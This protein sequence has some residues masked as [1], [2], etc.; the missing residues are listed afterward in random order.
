MRTNV[1]LS[2]IFLLI[3]ESI[4]FEVWDQEQVRAQN[5]KKL[6]PLPHDIVYESP[7]LDKDSF[8]N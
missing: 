5:E 1:I 7:E 8:F 3:V 6:L 2:Y 4:F